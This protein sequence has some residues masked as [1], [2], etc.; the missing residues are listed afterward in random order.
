MQE[1][2]A[3]LNKFKN[4]IRISLKN[5]RNDI[6]R[7]DRMLKEQEVLSDN[8]FFIEEAVY[9]DYS[10]LENQIVVMDFKLRLKNDLLFE[11]L[12]SIEQQHRDIV[13][14]SLCEGWSDSKIGKKLNLSRSKV[15]RIKQ[16]L[17]KEIYSVM[18]GG[19][20]NEDKAQRKN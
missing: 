13:Y 14:L 18:T 10:F 6:Y 5:H 12:T 17:K 4:F 16:K 15:Q 3:F 11:V 19:I 20:Q 7:K 8:P 9:D 2:I 1:N